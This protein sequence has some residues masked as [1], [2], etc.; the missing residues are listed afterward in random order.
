[1]N[2][3][4]QS[5]NYYERLGL[6]PDVSELQIKSAFFAAVRE[7]PPEKEADLH[8]MI[9]EAYDILVNPHSRIEYD[10][11]LTHGDALSSIE[12]E[13]NDAEEVEDNYEQ[14]RLL[15]KLINLAPKF[16]MYRN[17]LGLV[18]ME[19]EQWDDALSQLSK[20]IKIDSDN[21]VYHLNAGFAAK[22]MENLSEAE[23][24]FL[25][26]YEL[27]PEDYSP[28]RALASLYFFDYENAE[29]AHQIL[30]VAINADGQIDFQD[31][32]CIH[33]KLKYYTFKREE[34]E[35]DSQL[36]LLQEI[37]TND[38]E[39]S[40]VAYMLRDIAFQLY[41]INV[42]ELAQ[43][44]IIAAVDFTPDDD[45]LVAFKD[46][47][48]RNVKMVKSLKT[49]Q[50]SSKVHDFIQHLMTVY[51][52]HYYGEYEDSEY[53]EQMDQAMSI[54][55]N[56]MDVDPHS[57]K[58]KESFGYIK[59]NHPHVYKINSEF[60]DMIQNLPGASSV[61]HACPSCGDTFNFPKYNYGSYSCPKCHTDVRYDSTGVSRASSYSSSSSGCYIATAVYGDFEHDNVRLFRGFRDK[62]LLK[63]SF[64]RLFVK[65]YYALSP[66]L[67]KRLNPES[68]TSKVI[69]C[70]ILDKL[71]RIIKL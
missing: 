27:D 69:R 7:Y 56:I 9:R 25:K 16:G 15:K 24:H 66:F 51:V 46:E 32:F 64:G 48:L 44:F 59:R 17:K 49:I 53:R 63:S 60:F 33:D 37:I 30:D 31:F 4:P 1:V 61:Q 6:E 68:K 70:Y 39:K 41:E 10:T 34:K 2:Y 38:Q 29:K 35:L 26:A 22:G 47:I 40:F 65:V 8:K 14:E 20:A 42:F 55:K 18:Y 3:Q 67:A 13:L 58:I 50:K 23:N 43:K 45:D 57:T 36:S 5:S 11:R 62:V 12:E 28:S 19:L 54:L 52:A 21:P 71:A